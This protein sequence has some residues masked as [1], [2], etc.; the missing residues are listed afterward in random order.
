MS[1]SSFLYKIR[2]VRVA[3]GQV[4]GLQGSLGLALGLVSSIE[5]YFRRKSILFVLFVGVFTAAEAP[6]I[7]VRITTTWK[8]KPIFTNYRQINFFPAV[9]EHYHSI[10]L[11]NVQL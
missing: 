11:L 8:R 5:Q 9:I 6:C 3:Y 7:K 10:K 2:V 4:E 1:D